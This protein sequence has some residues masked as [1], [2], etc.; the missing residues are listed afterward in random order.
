MITLHWAVFSGR[1]FCWALGASS[2]P[3]GCLLLSYRWTWYRLRIWETV[4]GSGPQ[5]PIG[6]APEKSLGVK[7]G[8]TKDRET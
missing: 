6:M 4:L 5:T 1:L 8:G 7:D 3:S 2:V